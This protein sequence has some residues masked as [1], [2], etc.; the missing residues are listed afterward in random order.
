MAG[1]PK[2]RAEEAMLREKWD[3]LC[4]LIG[5]GLTDS[6]AL[7]QLGVTSTV[8][9]YRMM[10]KEEELAAAVV[11]AR[12]A[13]ADAMASTALDIVDEL[14]ELPIV[15][16]SDK[17]KA[18]IARADRRAWLAGTRNAR[19]AAR[20][21]G[22]VAVQVNVQALHLQALK[23]AALPAPAAEYVDVVPV[24]V[25]GG[26]VEGAEVESVEDLL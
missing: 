15:K 1:R 18:A 7:A 13:G 11:R 3:E 16:D 6:Q 26:E 23:G 19:Y 4:D 10:R 22:N 25:A 5:T 17:I 14:D 2:G 20:S 21:G 9:F 12:E 24:P 8:G